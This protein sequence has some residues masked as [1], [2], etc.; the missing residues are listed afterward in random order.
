L[1]VLALKLAD[2]TLTPAEI[3]GGFKVAIN[4][5]LNGT[6]GVDG[7]PVLVQLSSSDS[8]VS[9]P[10]TLRV[11][12]R[13]TTIAGDLQTRNVTEPTIVTVTGRAGGDTR[14]ATVRVLPVFISSVSDANDFPTGGGS[15][16]F[17]PEAGYS[18]S[19][20]LRNGAV[21]VSARLSNTNIWDLFFQGQSRDTLG[22]G[23]YVMDG[24]LVSSLSFSMRGRACNVGGMTGEFDVIDVECAGARVVCFEATFKQRCGTTTTT[25]VVR[26][27]SLPPLQ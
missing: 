21:F 14:S 24:S 12:D 26:V 7:S 8:I 19:G 4:V 15:H 17:A 10:P 20:Q 27:A 3:G 25:G 9:V 22:R 18:F 6:V 2:L 13:Q 16:Y 11:L 23:H 1:R 5:Q